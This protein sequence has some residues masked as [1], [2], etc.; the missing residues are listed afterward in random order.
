MVTITQNSFINCA[1]K[2][3]RVPQALFGVFKARAKVY[4]VT[5][6]FTP[7]EA[8]KKSFADISILQSFGYL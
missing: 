3:L 4:I 1:A 8:A 6:K 2:I 7:K 5:Y